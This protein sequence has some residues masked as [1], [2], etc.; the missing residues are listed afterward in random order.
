MTDPFELFARAAAVDEPALP[1]DVA[2]RLRARGRDRRRRRTAGLAVPASALAVVAVVL[3]PSA[4][5]DQDPSG[6]AQAPAS[7]EPVPVPSAAAQ[8]VRTTCDYRPSDYR[9]VVPVAPPPA[10]VALPSR[11]D[12][13]V[14]LSEGDVELVLDAASTPCTVASFLH[15]AREGY[16]DG[17][18]CHRVTT[19]RIRVLQCGDPSGTGSGGPGY[20]FDD[21]AA[22]AAPPSDGPL[23]ND[24]PVGTLAM[25]NAGPDMN[26]SQF[27]VVWGDSPSLPPDYTVFGRVRSG[28]D[29]V[30]AIGAR[31]S[32]RTNGASDG[33]PVRPVTIERVTT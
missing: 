32:D 4:D 9:P 14:A 17:T 30:Q 29:V 25:A 21:E 3:V 7:P 10:E 2:G 15:L 26:G 33:S 16:F 11:V 1:T 6:L 13:R 8:D 12:V 31:G 28:L 27:F 24:Y 5:L 19:E 22:A 20:A 18:D 23:R